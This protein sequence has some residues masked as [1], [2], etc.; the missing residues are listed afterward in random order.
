MSEKKNT[1]ETF[2]AVLYL[3]AEGDEGYE[4]GSRFRLDQQDGGQYWFK[5]RDGVA[6]FCLT[7]GFVLVDELEMNRLR[8]TTSEAGDQ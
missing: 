8:A 7:H 5:E 2:P 4:E 3:L 6:R 1:P